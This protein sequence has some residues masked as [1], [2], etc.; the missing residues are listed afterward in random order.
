M[1]KY[2][3]KTESQPTAGDNQQESFIL[4]FCQGYR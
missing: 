3:S 4:R 2:S 1:K